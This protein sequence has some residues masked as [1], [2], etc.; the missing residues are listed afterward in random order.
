[1]KAR[2]LPDHPQNPV[3]RLEKKWLF[4]SGNISFAHS[5]ANSAYSNSSYTTGSV[6]TDAM[7]IAPIYPLYVRDGDGHILHD[8]NGKV[9]D[10]GNGLY[11]YKTR[12][13]NTNHNSLN[14]LLL[15]TDRT[16]GN[17]F[18]GDAFADILLPKGFKVTVK[19]GA[20]I[21]SRE[22]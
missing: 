4:L 10:W 9:Y 20:W 3:G 14:S 12:P 22:R 17:N 16:I 7:N 19:G 21:L 6:F 5:I 13:V 15:E 8:K 1:M 18:T 11:A 2:V